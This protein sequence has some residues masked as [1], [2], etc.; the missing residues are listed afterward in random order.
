MQLKSRIVRLFGQ[1]IIV[2]QVWKRK[3][4]IH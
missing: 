2:G 1:T 3:L 4:Y